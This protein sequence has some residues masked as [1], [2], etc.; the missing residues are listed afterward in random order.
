MNE[1]VAQAPDVALDLAAEPLEVPAQTG[2]H[3]RFPRHCRGANECWPFDLLQQEHILNLV[4]NI[5]VKVRTSPYYDTMTW[6]EHLRWRIVFGGRTRS[7]RRP[8]VTGDASDDGRLGFKIDS[9]APHPARVWNFW[10][11]GKANYPADCQAGK[12]TIAV[13]PEVVDIARAS[14]QF[15]VRVVRYLAADAGIRQFLDIGTGLSTVNNT[16]QVAQQI[17]PESRVVYVDND[18][19]VLIHARA[20]LTSNPEGATGYIEADVRDVDTILDG[21]AATLD[22]A[23]PVAIIMAGIL[24][25]IGDDAEARAIVARLLAPAP[26][27]SHLAVTHLT[28]EVGGERVI[29]AAR[30][31]NQVAPTP[32][33]LRSL[34]QIAAFF[35]GLELVEPGVVPCPRW[36]P[37]TYG[38]GSGQD[39]DMFCGLGRK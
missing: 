30:Q 12:Q 20:L 29:E 16:H 33:H 23:R 28:S 10:L 3:P 18:P 38:I 15:L 31:W 11:G 21:A 36:R 22:L 14:R 32:Y 2:L 8:T 1:F 9:P 34:D 6:D 27:G 17:A 24:P 39:M 5:V 4:I 26:A 19:L 35:E 13:L 7:S 37:R 25:F